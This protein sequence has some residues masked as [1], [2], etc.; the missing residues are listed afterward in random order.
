MIEIM[1]DRVVIPEYAREY[2]FSPAQRQMAFDRVLKRL[3][4]YPIH[5]QRW[6][7]SRSL[8]EHFTRAVQARAAEHRVSVDSAVAWLTIEALHELTSPQHLSHLPMII[9]RGAGSHPDSAS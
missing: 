1:V 6:Y 7:A 3:L 5:R 2:L 9:L 4:Q 8:T